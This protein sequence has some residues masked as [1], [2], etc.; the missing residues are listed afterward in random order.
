MITW[1]CFCWRLQ[2]IICSHK[3]SIVQQRTIT[4][5]IV[6]YCIW[7][8]LQ[9]SV[10]IFC[11]DKAMPF[12]IALVDD[13]TM[14]FLLFLYMLQL[15][16]LKESKNAVVDKLLWYKTVSSYYEIVLFLLLLVRENIAATTSA[17]VKARMI[18]SKAQFMWHCVTQTN[19][20]SSFVLFQ[21]G[22]M[23]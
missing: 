11:S 12:Y 22:M 7:A 9:V 3:F 4:Q 2:K 8:S 19:I 1:L 13:D 14:A 15:Q 10:C 6:G 23:K 18:Q 5:F 17:L 21:L 16:L 20:K